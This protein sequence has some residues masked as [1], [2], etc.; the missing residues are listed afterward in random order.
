VIQITPERLAAVYTMLRTWPPFHRWNLPPAELVRF[1]V[2][3]TSA[4]QAL[5]WIDG[6]THNIAISERKH[7]TLQSLIASMAHEIIHVRQRVAGTETRSEHN[8]EFRRLAKR[9]CDIHGFDYGQFMG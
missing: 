3:R 1:K 6:D 4:W 5:W 2:S 9:V 7:S 8:A